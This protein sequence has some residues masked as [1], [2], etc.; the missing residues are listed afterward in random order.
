VHADGQVR[1]RSR[2]GTDT[3]PAS[4]SLTDPR[5]LLLGRYD[6]AGVLQYTGRATTVFRSA[7]P[8]LAGRL[9][10]PA[11]GHPWTGWTFSAGWGTRRRLD[12]YLVQPDMVMEVAVDVA[13][14]RAGRRRHPLRPH[15]IRDGGL[16]VPRGVVITGGVCAGLPAGPDSR[17][18]GG[19][20][21]L[22]DRAGPTREHVLGDRRIAA[23]C[24]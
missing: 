13:R 3:T 6:A 1:L 11:G 7:G 5:T 4:G 20:E 21:P 15:R 22:G 18:G 2:Q 16:S 9:A 14:D 23:R 12:V 24:R 8:A 19:L 17:R 10:E